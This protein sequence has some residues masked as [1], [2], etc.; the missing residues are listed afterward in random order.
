MN[1]HEAELFRLIAFAKPLQAELRMMHVA[2]N[3][4]LI[5]NKALAEASINANIAHF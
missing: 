2:S 3:N 4:G 1:D 5:V